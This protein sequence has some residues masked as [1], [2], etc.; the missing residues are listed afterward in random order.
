MDKST[1]ENFST[2]QPPF[3][4]RPNR[5]FCLGHFRRTP[6]PGFCIPPVREGGRSKKSKRVLE[7]NFCY[8]S[9]KYIDL[10]T[11][12]LKKKFPPSNHPFFRAQIDISVWDI[13]GGPPVQDFVYPPVREGGKVEY[14]TWSTSNLIHGF[15]L[16][17]RSVCISSQNQYTST[18][19]TPNLIHG[20]I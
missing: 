1:E 3:F 19:S 2:L 18:W 16:T 9:L 14:A 11:N 17:S 4:S 12:Q 8:K 20:F 15:I 10:W 7:D 13:L 5:Y 6:S